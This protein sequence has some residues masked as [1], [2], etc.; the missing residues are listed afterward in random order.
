M[1][2]AVMITPVASAG[3]DTCW[4]PVYSLLGGLSVVFVF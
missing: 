2:T 1:T 4:L 3:R